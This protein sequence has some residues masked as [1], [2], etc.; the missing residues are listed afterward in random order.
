[1]ARGVADRLWEIEDRAKLVEEA[2]AKLG[3]RGRS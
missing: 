3:K 2:E 1:M